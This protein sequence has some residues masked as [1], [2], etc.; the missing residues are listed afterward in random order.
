MLQ[1]SIMLNLAAL[2]GVAVV[3]VMLRRALRDGRIDRGGA[4]KRSEVADPCSRCVDRN[5]YFDWC[6]YYDLCCADAITDCKR[7]PEKMTYSKAQKEQARVA[8]AAQR[9]KEAGQ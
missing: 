7:V 6:D 9:G 1:V 2:I 4:T 5:E 3:G 8:V